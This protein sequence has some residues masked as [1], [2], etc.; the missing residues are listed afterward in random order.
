VRPV[1]NIAP[2]ISVLRRIGLLATF[3]AASIAVAAVPAAAPSEK[4]RVLTV[5]A[6]TDNFPY[7]YRDRN[8]HLTGYGVE[9]LDA[10]AE[11]MHVRLQR[12]EVT[13]TEDVANLMAERCDIGQFHSNSGPNPAALYSQPILINTGD[14]FVRT[15]DH[16]YTTF[17]DLRRGRARI[18]AH[19]QARNYLLAR[20]FDPERIQHATSSEAMRALATGEVDAVL[21]SRLTGLT[22]AHYLNIRNVE[23]L[24]WDLRDFRV[25]FCIATR[26][27]DRELLEQINEALATL[28]TTGR[29]VDIYARWFGRYETLR[30]SLR[31]MLG[32]AAIVLALALLATLGLLRRQHLLRQR[33]ARQAEDLRLSHE[34]LAEAQRFAQIGHSRRSHNPSI[35]AEWSEESYRI[36]ELPPAAGVPD[37]DHLIALALPSD[38]PRWREAIDT[39][40]R[41]GPPYDF[42]ITIVTTAGHRK[43]LNVRGRPTYDANGRQNG[44]FGTVQDVTTSRAATAAL[45]QSELLLRALYEH[46]P[47]ALCVVERQ[48]NDWHF[49]SVNP[50]AVRQFGVSVDSV[51]G[52]AL[53]AIG[54]P[55]ERCQFWRDKFERT[56]ADGETIRFEFESTDL[57]RHFAAAV[58]PLILPGHP[59]R[60]C[61]LSEEITTRI[62]KDAELSQ[63]RRLRAIG[64]LVGGIAH[65][66]N[67]L[68]TP[69]AL[70]TEIILGQSVNHPAL[71]ADLEVIAD[72]AR[73]AGELTRR[74]L[75][76]GRRTDHQTE[77]IDVAA[78]VAANIALVQHTFDRRIV[79]DATVPAGLPPLHLPA[80]VLQQIILN[81]LLNARDA[82][83]AKLA[84][85]PRPDWIAH[86]EVAATAI[87]S[88]GLSPSEPTSPKG[89][90]TWVQITV[91]DNGC[92]MQPSVRERLFEPF[93]TTKGVGSG[94]GLGLATIWH[95]VSESDGRIGVDTVPD[96]GTAFHITLPVRNAPAASPEPERTAADSD[97][98]SGSRRFLLAE[99]EKSVALVVSR[100]LTRKGHQVTIESNG[101][102]ALQ[103]LTATPKAFDAVIM[104]LNMPGLTGVE[105]AQEARSRGFTRPLIVMSGRIGDEE[106]AQ[107]IAAKVDA[108]ILKPFPIS[109]FEET[110]ARVFGSPAGGSTQS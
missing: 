83:A 41:G 31:E 51:Q 4:E 21:T 91:R 39:T 8:G 92:G 102:H 18:A 44:T 12:V 42:D 87:S 15:G 76:F 24:G 109:K 84:R 9:M 81:L 53:A 62:L 50:E 98:P 86:I 35:P 108:L 80:G 89:S 55:V 96:E 52:A 63:S 36:F 29:T 57:R 58:V 45:Q 106:R 26:H 90:E 74:L 103:T 60:C 47:V 104:D 70:N 73:R 20:G 7:S 25:A 10:V 82:L 69:I 37:F 48:S 43:V 101:Q 88:S 97:Q 105:L 11:V 1:L 77:A 49:L 100:L 30:P 78:T 66:F 99:D 67:N 28:S 68:L 22:Q 54:F 6:A 16:R 2:T 33:I 94:T 95:L 40:E 59:P 5:S 93:F 17:D 65:E 61:L 19:V 56:T 23:P 72:A 27:G 38:Q 3:L 85:P 32:P 46:L 79:I 110:I 13:S 14:V 64:E 71:R 107:L 34:I 75:T